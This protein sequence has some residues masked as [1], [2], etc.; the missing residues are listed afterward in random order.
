MYD[1]KKSRI[2]VRASEHAVKIEGSAG[3]GEKV[4]SV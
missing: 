4:H 1:E 3:L 2:R